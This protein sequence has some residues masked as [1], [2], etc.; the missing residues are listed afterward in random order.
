MACHGVSA[1]VIG[2]GFRDVAA[3]YA[4]DTTAESRLVVKV[5]SGGTGAWGAVPT[6]AQPLL[7]DADART[8]V[9]WILAGAK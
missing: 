5:K 9:Q 4:G 7:S 2:P 6:P 8:L 3:R 1:K